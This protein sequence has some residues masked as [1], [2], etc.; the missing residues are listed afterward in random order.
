MVKHLQ[1]FSF[2]M[3]MINLGL[4]LSRR[5]LLRVYKKNI[6]KRGRKSAH[7]KRFT[8]ATEPYHSRVVQNAKKKKESASALWL[9]RVTRIVYI[10]ELIK[11]DLWRCSVY[12]QICLVRVHMLRDYFLKLNKYPM[13]CSC[14]GSFYQNIKNSRL[15]EYRAISIKE[16]LI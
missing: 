1:S 5:Q 9:A 13:L 11:T 2:N 3:T 10:A 16:K 8:P 12:I 14:S 15:D 7:W 4:K 6:T